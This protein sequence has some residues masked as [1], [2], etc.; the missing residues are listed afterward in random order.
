MRYIAD[1]AGL[2]LTLCAYLF[3]LLKQL[4]EWL[5]IDYRWTD[6]DDDEENP[7]DHKCV[8][9]PSALFPDPK[10]TDGFIQCGPGVNYEIGFVCH[11]CLP[12][13][14]T[15]PSGAHFDPVAK[16]CTNGK[17]VDTG[18]GNENGN[19]PG[20]YEHVHWCLILEVSFLYRFFDFLFVFKQRWMR[21]NFTS[22]VACIKFRWTN[23]SV[24]NLQL[25]LAKTSTAIRTLSTFECDIN[26]DESLHETDNDL[27]NILVKISKNS[28]KNF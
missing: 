4:I 22:I 11:C 26:N 24:V 28:Q 5:I 6:D 3:Y 19:R 23:Y 15:C 13:R 9:N 17:T 18:N 14:L 8:D 27:L 25:N 12:Y 7:C 20:V 10:R 16:V 2:W 1:S 21:S